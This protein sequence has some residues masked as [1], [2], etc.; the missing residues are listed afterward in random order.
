MFA[1][2]QQRNNAPVKDGSHMPQLQNLKSNIFIKEP[3]I[4]YT[5]PML[6]GL[7][8]YFTFYGYSSREKISFASQKLS[9]HA[10]TW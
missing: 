7:G 6:Q 8:T 3:F 4:Y 10:L 1:K 2:N 5:W 9:K